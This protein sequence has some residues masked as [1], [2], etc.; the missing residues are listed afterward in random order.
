[1]ETRI[2]SNN[3]KYSIRQILLESIKGFKSSFYLARQLA[4]RDI[5]SQHRQSILGIF[6]VL[7]PVVMNAM[8]WI[9]L[10][11]TGVINLSETGIPYPVFVL[12]GTTIWSIFGECLN[13]PMTTVNS[14]RSI[15]TK[16]NF[17]KEAL[18][19]LGFIKLFFNLTIKLSLILFF[20]IYFRILPSQTI[21]LF[22][23]FLIVMIL[24]FT[25]IG[26]L[27]MPLGV[28]YNDISKL[29]P[30]GLQLLMYVSPVLYAVPK[31]GLMQKVMYLN[32]LTYL[33]IDIRNSLTGM[34]IANWM[35]WG[36]LVLV[37]FFLSLIAM[38]VYRVSIPIIT[39]RMSA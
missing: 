12:I 15:L 31:S 18:I 22:V 24:L 17:E 20:L 4:K 14:N 29:I 19:S 30:I 13:M 8:I 1:M 36:V 11:G 37:T 23:P 27:L 21:L 26:V 7:V 33:L 6:W 5:K 25:S 3:T 28:L 9:F 35:F 10:Q 32:P 16:I 34:P 38:V 39:E 2:Y